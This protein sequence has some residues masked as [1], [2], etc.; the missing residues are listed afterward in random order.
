MNILEKIKKNAAEFPD[1]LMMNTCSKNGGGYAGLAYP[2]HL[3]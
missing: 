3:I 2:G 1:R